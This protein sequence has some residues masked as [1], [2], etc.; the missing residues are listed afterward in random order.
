[1]NDM[2]LT[3]T[4]PGFGG[5][6]ANIDGVRIHYLLGGGVRLRRQENHRT[7]VVD[8][9]ATGGFRSDVV[10][11]VVRLAPQANP[12]DRLLHCRDEMRM[13]LRRASNALRTTPQ[14]FTLSRVAAIA[15]ESFGP[16]RGFC[17]H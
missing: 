6:T 14:I 10:G 16:G 3:G 12:L 17:Q 7:R 1:M 5:N 9:R 4:I 8:M 13:E 15:V 2:I 11:G